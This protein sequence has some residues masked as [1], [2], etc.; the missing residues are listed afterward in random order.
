MAGDWPV[1]PLFIGLFFISLSG[2]FACVK[3][4]YPFSERPPGFFQPITGLRRV[5]RTWVTAR[6]CRVRRSLFGILARPRSL[7]Q[8]VL[9]RTW[10]RAER[11]R[12]WVKPFV[13]HC[14]GATVLA[15]LQHT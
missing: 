13:D 3:A 2:M 6:K 4:M 15:H 8:I 12:M 9:G 10:R 14:L 5:Y 7:T 1:G 11:R